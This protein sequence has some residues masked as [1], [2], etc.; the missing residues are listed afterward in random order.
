MD[1]TNTIIDDI[2]N[3]YMP[4]LQQGI[5]YL[6]NL[7][8]ETL[9]QRISLLL[10]TNASKASIQ[11][12]SCSDSQALRSSYQSWSRLSRDQFLD[13]YVKHKYDKTAGQMFHGAIY[14]GRKAFGTFWEKSWENVNEARRPAYPSA[15][16]FFYARRADE[17]TISI[18]PAR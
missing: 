16:W 3:D 4:M 2:I 15:G 12:L 10:L 11:R 13:E 1:E 7:G 17:W 9:V 18:V 6:P 14:N 8:L 5:K